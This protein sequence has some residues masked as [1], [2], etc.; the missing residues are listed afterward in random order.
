MPWWKRKV[1]GAATVTL[2]VKHYKDEEGIENIDISQTLTGGIS[3][4]FRR[5]LPRFVFTLP[6]HLRPLN[7]DWIGMP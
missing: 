2:D 4:E 5:N 1:I 3:G 7:M 6:V